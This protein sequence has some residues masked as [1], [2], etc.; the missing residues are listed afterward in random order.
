MTI[1]IGKIKL[2]HVLYYS[3]LAILVALYVFAIYHF[4][5]PIPTCH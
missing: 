3:Y 2:T 4:A 1:S 5:Q